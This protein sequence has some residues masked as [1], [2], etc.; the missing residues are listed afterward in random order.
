MIGFCLGLFSFL[1]LISIEPPN[2]MNPLDIRAA[3]VSFMMAVFWVTEAISIFA[4]SFLPI[5]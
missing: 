3:A 4:T 1:F 5:A 2:D